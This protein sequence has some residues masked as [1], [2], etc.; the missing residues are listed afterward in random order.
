MNLP[1]IALSLIHD[2][3]RPVTRPDWRKL[4]RLPL[5][6]LYDEIM[7]KKQKQSWNYSSQIRLFIYNIQMGNNWSDLRDYSKKYGL[8]Q[9]SEHFG[10]Q[11]K[12]LEHILKY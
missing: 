7:E 9:C 1:P 4:N 10:I 12:E 6:K 5:Y 8:K 2:F 11:Y 3:S